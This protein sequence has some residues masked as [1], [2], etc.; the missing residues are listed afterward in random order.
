M[1]VIVLAAHRAK[2]RNTGSNLWNPGETSQLT[3]LF[4]AKR[5]QGDERKID[6]YNHVKTRARNRWRQAR[7]GTEGSGLG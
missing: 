6:I 7:E 3:R 2:K 5:D 1:N 4:R